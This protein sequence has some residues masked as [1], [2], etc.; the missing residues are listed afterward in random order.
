MAYSSNY[1]RQLAETGDYESEII[2]ADVRTT[3]K[4][5]Q[6]LNLAFRLSNNIPVYK[7][8]WR[9]SIEPTDFNH[10]QIAEL[11]TALGIEEDIEGDFAL[12]QAIKNKKL[13][14]S[15]VKEYNDK[16]QKEINDVKAFKPLQTQ[17]TEQ[18]EI[19]EDDLPF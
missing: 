13:I 17:S 19:N 15:V 14:L 5:N 9:D 4:G 1:V 16:S 11:L 18:V 8:I 2:N 3:D 6:Y 10:Q 12:I 7:K